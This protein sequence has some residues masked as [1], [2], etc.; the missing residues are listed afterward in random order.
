MFLFAC[1]CFRCVVCLL[2][3]FDDF[4][5]VVWFGMM[6]GLAYAREAVVFAYGVDGE[7]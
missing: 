5:F 1:V 7:C 2:L 4:C 3:V 6:L